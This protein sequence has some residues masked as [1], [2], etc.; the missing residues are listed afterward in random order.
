MKRVI[1]IIIFLVIFSKAL[2]PQSDL[3]WIIDAGTKSDAFSYSDTQKLADCMPQSVSAGSGLTKFM[4]YPYQFTLTKRMDITID[5]CGSSTNIPSTEIRLVS[6]SAGKVEFDNIYIPPCPSTN[7]GIANK[8]VSGLPP[9]TYYMIVYAHSQNVKLDSTVTTTIQGVPAKTEYNLG[10]KTTSFT[11][12]HTQNT[13]ECFNMYTMHSTCANDVFY[14]FTLTKPMEV[15]ISHCGSQ[16][17]DTYLHLLD[18]S[19]NR[20]VYNDNY[21]GIGRC[22]PVTHAYLE[23]NL[24]AGTYYAVSEGYGNGNITTTITGTKVGSDDQNYVHT[25]TMTNENG[26]AYL[27]EIRYFDGLGRP[28]ET[29]QK[30]ITPTKAD[31]VT[32]LEYDA[33]GRESKSWLPVR[34]ENNRGAFVSFADFQTGASNTYNNTTYN[35]ASDAEPYSYPVYEPSPLNRIV[36]QFGAGKNWHINN[37]PVNTSYLTNSAN[38]C[39]RYTV[40]DNKTSAGI[41]RS[42][43]YAANELYV[44]K[45]NDEEGNTSYEAKDKLGQVVYTRQVNGS[46]ILHT[47]YVYDSFG[48]LR[49]VLPPLAVDKFTSGSWTEST[50]LFKDYAYAYKYDG[51]N[52]CIAKKIPGAEWVYYVYDRADRLIFTQNGEQR[53]TGEWSFSIPD[54]FGRVVLTGICKNTLSYTGN[55]LDG[56]AV[57]AERNN[58]SNTYKGYTLSGVTLDSFTVLTVNYYDDYKFMGYNGIPIKTDSDFGYEAV[59]GYGQQYAGTG[60]YEHKGLLTGTQVA[61]NRE[62]YAVA[63]PGSAILAG[64]VAP[65]AA[66]FETQVASTL[67]KTKYYE[68]AVPQK[69]MATATPS[70]PSGESSL[71]KIDPNWAYL[72]TVM[73]YDYKGQV[74]QSK[75]HNHL[76]GVEKEYVAYNFTGQPTQRKQ[77]HSAKDKA[78]QTEARTYAYDH[79]GRLTQTKY[80]LNNGV[81]IVPVNNT[82]DELGRLKTTK[83]YSQGKLLSTYSYNIRSWQTRM[84]NNQFGESLSY[85]YNG[86]IS[87]MSWFQDGYRQ[88]YHFS[89]DNLSR[90]CTAAFTGFNGEKYGTGY[91]YD[92]H[93]NTTSL[94]RYGSVIPALGAYAY[95]DRLT[96]NYGNSNQLRNINDSGENVFTN[97]SDFK[98]YKKGSGVEYAYNA[99]G[100]MTQD[101]NKGISE[102]QY[103]RLNLP[104]RIDIK[105][106]VAEARNEYTYTAAGTKLKVVH[107]WNP[108][109]SNSPVVGS[110]VDAGSLTEVKTVDYVGNKIYTNGVLEKILIENGYYENGK[111]YF[112]IR[113]HLG[114]NRI[115]ADQSGNNVIQSTQYY[116]FGMVMVET[117]R[118]KQAFKFGGKELDMMNGLNLYDFVARGYDPVTGRF[119]TPDPLC[120]KYYSISSYAYCLNN[121]VKFI[122]PDGKSTYTRM[123]DDGTYTV[124]GGK[125]DGD[126]SIYVLFGVNKPM[127]FL[128]ESLTEYSF[129]DDHGNPVIGAVIDPEDHTGEIFLN[130][131]II[132][133]P[134]G[135][136][137]YMWNATG[138]KYYD[139]KHRGINERSEKMSENQYRYRGMPL[140]GVTSVVGNRGEGIKIYASARDVGN[141]AAGYMAGR[142]GLLWEEARTGFDL[143]ETLQHYLWPTK[144]G[145]PTQQAEKIGYD[146]GY[147][148]YWHK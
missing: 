52:R 138:E 55:P 82:Y 131:E 58:T 94:Y 34:V 70:I 31:L 84:D 64:D 3:S 132:N 105:S 18:A 91:S 69:A 145:Q 36:Q 39:P 28:V 4:L 14:K 146:N 141:V 47:C 12:S 40:S 111:Y 104:Q 80:T 128:G 17:S 134:L 142:N 77:V 62:L 144:E 63:V 83:P 85:S 15:I 21:M 13:E 123:N 73:Y 109:Y 102:I 24:E 57:K 114:N 20:I 118:E 51:R 45:I 140:N 65:F 22:V 38:F 87:D 106:P 110:A 139:F 41:T 33:F 124:V 72:A 92:K 5:N 148:A 79:A 43:Y 143:L 127:G 100:A 6:A 44:T 147:P 49:A 103:N 25:R 119:L 136:F 54:I 76:G 93:G 101:M 78:T 1:A 74:I 68:E 32:Y 112:Y 56:V 116:P 29:V 19:G 121:P 90:L 126:K 137:Q 67:P 60:G 30:G 48:N 37:K 71:Y 9:G 61:Y 81:R 133:T 129:F 50:Q 97:P 16:V 23:L 59:S 7:G 108:A 89:Y 117:N 107:R 2:Y 99:N 86:N 88:S 135:L 95:I 11:Y 42:G 130:R 46:E 66:N 27:D 8:K 10:E 96:M 75:S 115:V 26:T 53:K 35:S 125:I 113:D 120:E 122:D 98:D